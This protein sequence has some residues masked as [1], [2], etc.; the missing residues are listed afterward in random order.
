MDPNSGNQTWSKWRWTVYPGRRLA[1][2]FEPIKLAI[3]NFT[4]RQF[5][6]AGR[7]R[8]TEQLDHYVI[9]LLTEG[10]PAH[11][12]DFV[13]AMARSFETFFTSQFGA[14]TRTTLDPPTFMA[15]SRQDGSPRDQLIILPTINFR[16]MAKG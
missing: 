2:P 9:E 15:G 14:N 8:I 10:K 3:A 4:S 13:R 6:H 16:E 11:D 7:M 12:P 1:L 5:G